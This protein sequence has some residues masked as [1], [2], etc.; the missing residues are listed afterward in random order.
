[1]QTEAEYAKQHYETGD[2]AN[3]MHI[4]ESALTRDPDNPSA[5]ALRG[6]ILMKQEKIVSAVDAFERAGLIHPLS[7]EA[8]IALA[9]G[10]G[11][12]GRNSLSRD[13]LLSITESQ[14]LNADFS[15]DVAEGLVV[16]GFPEEA[17]QVCKRA[18]RRSPLSAELPYHAGYYAALSGAT[19]QV[20]ESCLRHAIQLCPDNFHYRVGLSSFLSNTGRNRDAITELNTIVPT[21]LAEITCHCCLKRMANLFFDNDLL[22][23]AEQCAIQLA[24]QRLTETPTCSDTVAQRG[25]NEQNAPTKIVQN[26]HGT[27]SPVGSPK[28]N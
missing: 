20:I 2:Y 4:V 12:L 22:E 11:K 27:S 14:R 15:I 16:A 28:S 8:S 25:C 3:A 23:Q 26:H 1:M 10:Y 19:A 17:F 18:S 7:V 6:Q 5:L 21:R 13:L 24:K 9:I